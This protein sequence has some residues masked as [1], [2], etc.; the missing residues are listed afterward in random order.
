MKILH[1]RLTEINSTIEWIAQQIYIYKK[2]FY[3]HRILSILSCQYYTK[4]TYMTF[5]FFHQKAALKS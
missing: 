1:R 5:Y 4:Q 2:L 3:I